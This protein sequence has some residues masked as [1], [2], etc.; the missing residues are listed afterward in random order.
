MGNGEWGMGGGEEDGGIDG[1]PAP[2]DKSIHLR[3][4]FVCISHSF[5]MFAPIPLVN[6]QEDTI[7]TTFMLSENH[8]LTIPLTQAECFR[9]GSFVPQLL[10]ANKA[11]QR[12]LAYGDGVMWGTIVANMDAPLDELRAIKQNTTLARYTRIKRSIELVSRILHPF[13]AFRN[14][15]RWMD[16]FVQHRNA[17]GFRTIHRLL[18]LCIGLLRDMRNVKTTSTP[19]E[20][21]SLRTLV[22]D[23]CKLCRMIGF[24]TDEWTLARP[25]PDNVHWL[26]HELRMHCPHFRW[27]T[28]H[29]DPMH[30]TNRFARTADN[31]HPADDTADNTNVS[32][33]VSVRVDPVAPAVVMQVRRSQRLAH[34]PGVSYHPFF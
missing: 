6:P 18:E 10:I 16:I 12:H 33:T 31:M 24:Q 2:G 15:A 3:V 28:D 23:C 14:I 11:S 9:I 7:P 4:C 17:M 29:L 13:I 19:E 1:A 32:A 20:V 8:C 27:R 25:F 26:A 30:C 22:D 5:A 34:K 21:E